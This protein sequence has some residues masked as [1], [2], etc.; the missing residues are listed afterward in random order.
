MGDSYRIKTEL[1]IN[2]SINVQLDQEF[3]F[4]EIL[5]LKI[6]QTDIYS[7]SCA[8]Y[9]VLVGRVTANNGFG[10]P[11]ARVSIF[12]PIEQVDE[13]NPLITSIYPYKS[14]ND[15]NDDGY[16]YNLLPYTPSYSKH[17]A[18]GTL[19]SKSDV[20]TGSTTVEIYD[21]YYRF[22]SRTNDSGDYM[23]MGVPLGERT[24]VMDVDLS[25]IGE[26]SLTPQDL[27]RMGLATEAQVAGN[28]FRS[29]TDLN[30]L[31]Q[32][33]NLIKNAEISPLWGDPEICDISIN[34]VDFDLRDD[35]N[36]D[37][38]PTSVFMGSMFS[39]PDKFRIRRNCKP[40]D[41]MGNLCG[42]TSGPGQI[43]AIRQTTQQ[44]ED[45]NPVLEVYELEQ[46]GN[47]IDGDGTWLTELP[48]NL[49]YVVTNEFG[50]RVLSNDSTL[51]IPTKGKYRF[52]VKWSQANDL[53]IQTRRPS[54]LVPNVKEY[55]WE[56]STTDPTN[57]TIQTRKKLQESSYYFGLAWSGYTN[58]FTGSEQIDR[59]NE[60]IDCEDTFYEFQF[61]RVYT[62]SSLID[63]Y[64]KG[65]GR[66]R[67]IGIK[68]IDDDSCDSTINKFPVNDG[69]KNFDLLYFLFSIIF[70][71]IQFI[72]ISLL[73]VA[74]L[75]LFIYT[76]VI[77]ALC[78]LCGIKLLGGRPF[79]FICNSLR[80]KCE[81]K[82]FTI[83][84]PM[85]TYPDCQSCSCNEAQLNSNALLSGTNGVLSYVS[86]PPSYVEGL[87]S[88]FGADGTPSD[89]VQ[90]KSSI[91][92]QAIAGNNDEVSDLDVF[93]TPK[94]SVVRFL[95]D[96]SDEDKHFAF[97]ESLTVGERINI[98]NTRPSYFDNLNKIKVTFAQDSNFGKFHFDN[99][100]T[101]LSNQFYES[102]QLLTSVNPGTT[103]DRNFLY[104]A[105]TE[106]NIVNGITGTTIQQATSVNVSY[107]TTQTTDQT[108]LYSLPTGSTVSRQVYPQDREYFQVVTAITVADA[109]KIWNIGELESFPNVLAAPSRLILA[110]KRL[111]GYRRNDKD[112]LISP[113]NAFSDIE[114]QYILILQ[115]GVD[116]YSPKYT[117]EYRLGRIFGKNIDDT[118]LTIT[119]QTRLNI[120]IQKLTQTNISV[121]P[122][123]QNGMFYPSYFFT[124]GNDFSGFTTSTVGYYGSIDANSNISRLKTQNMGGVTAMVSTTNNDFY[125]PNQNS[126]KY[127]SSEDV[128]GASYIFSNITAFSLD[129]LSVVV[130]GASAG[131]GA[132][133]L[134]FVALA[135]FFPIITI[136]L[137][138]AGIAAAFAAIF[139]VNFNYNDVRY[140]YFTPNAYPS[141]SANPMSI[142]SKVINVMRTD[143]L[144]S[145]DALNGSSWETN[146]ALLQQNNNFIFY[147][148]PELDPSI[149]LPPYSLGA[150]IPTSDLEGLP[151]YTTVLSSFN[152]ENMVGLDCYQ[153]FGNTFEVN[154]ECTTKDAVEKG[155]YMFL[156]R[157]LAD[158]G[159][160]LSNFN[161]WGYRFRFFYGLCRG[162][163]SQSFM[164]NWIN[165]S[166]YFFPIQVDTFYNRQ[167]KVGQVRFCEDVVY[168]NRDSNNFYYRSS[169]YNFT[170]NKFVG[171]IVNKLDGGI[172]DLN[173]LYPTTVINLGMKDYFYSEITFDPT[174]RG[175]ILPNINP[176]SYGDTSDLINLFVISRITDENFLEQ[177]IPAGDNSINQLFSRPERRIDGDLA[178]LL[179][180]NSE[181]GNVNF[182]PEYYDVLSGDTN[183][184]TQILGT[185]ENPTMAVWFSST[186]EDLQTK[187]YLTPGRINF[188]GTDDIGYYPYPYSITS[189][190]VPFYQ[191]N[192]KNTNL[193]FGNQYNDWATA[194]SDIVQNVRYQSLDRYA[195]DTQYFWSNNSESNDLNARG[196]IFNV[197]GTVG[198][199]QYIATG[200][201]K[202]KFVVGAPFQFYFGTIVGQTA[203]DKFKTKYSVDE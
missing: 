77:Q 69:F 196:Y 106:D 67:F 33:I 149:G 164:N 195:S 118:E 28:K 119:A 72:G 84:L 108:V 35:A 114:N 133:L 144:P 5:S 109:I 160:D 43:L 181:I 75:L 182:S 40:K 63:Q 115:R 38:Q 73:I 6:Q 60:I 98:F 95:S 39:S 46:A 152:C 168:Y 192:L 31:P 64:K 201:L 137:I 136:L 30:S 93:K 111:R 34:R 74:H 51:G 143:R 178:Q 32:I 157:P 140:Q 9:G 131:V 90:I 203:L 2:K 48:M 162:V 47:V 56:N 129:P 83:R 183:P 174:T 79:Q 15:K 23:I 89:D 18:T 22:T 87:E 127:D 147:E 151:N 66:G 165:G 91:F 49:E 198:N 173:L 68:E 4:L 138:G 128:S 171:K 3:E 12:I 44:D 97:S 59:L 134:P 70:T 10:V 193:I 14:P 17:S 126:A 92:A 179:S 194:S 52:K 88:I 1:G 13:S 105:Q 130:L 180:I 53:T 107:A 120:P 8:D 94:S 176:T 57:S 158:L 141:L 45:G 187:D 172:N 27:I 191:W 153:G 185:A 121:Q 132:T 37:I 65:D 200:A 156:R 19:P 41:N 122:F 146:P 139:A 50:E 166:L 159:K 21:K 96:E 26:F 103:T 55:G 161:E 170:T 117:N 104:T 71:V 197:N 99:T 24:I 163:L 78:F 124:P 29:S 142:S 100:T 101:V 190:V 199:G 145:S 135:P 155:C 112:F 86:F 76:T 61:N 62:V 85:I 82:D 150:E 148:I 177:L 188:R 113:L 58:G 54:Y 20:L 125:S 25:D 167:N 110:K 42:L 7:R 81:T 123:N 169:P 16:R 189:Q 102:G 11:N 202:Q 184:P 116:P 80:I 175:F 36:V 186:T 154:Q